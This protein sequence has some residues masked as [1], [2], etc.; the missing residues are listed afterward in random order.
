MRGG[1]R[2]ALRDCLTVEEH[3]CTLCRG[4]S[5]HLCL[6]FFWWFCKGWALLQGIL[7]EC[8]VSILLSVMGMLHFFFPSL[9]EHAFLRLVNLKKGCTAGTSR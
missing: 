3:P 4:C 8:T 1:R 9:R 6:G 2:V 7:R 5:V